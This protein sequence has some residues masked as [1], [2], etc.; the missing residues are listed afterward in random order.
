MTSCELLKVPARYETYECLMKKNV[1]IF[2][3][4]FIPEL[5]LFGL[6]D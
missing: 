6:H 2:I 3:S 1:T 4:V 5:W